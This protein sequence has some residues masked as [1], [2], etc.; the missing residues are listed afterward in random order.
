MKTYTILLRGVMP[1]GKNKVPMAGLRA[2]LVGAGVLDVR[3]YIQSGNVVARSDLG[4]AALE[5]LVHDVIADHFG[6]DIV[7]V[8]RIADRFRAILERNPFVGV[9]TSK[10]YFTILASKP[11]ARRLKDFLAADY[12]PDEVRVVGDV[13]YVL[14]DTRYSDSKVNN[15]FIE[16]K[17]GVSATT[18]NFNTMSKLVE[19]SRVV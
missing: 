8:A 6:G 4:Q 10:L 18:R 12:A 19:L 9:D 11:D 13:V 3:T 16:R 1:T 5:K 15:N 17:L 7:V 14:Y 2:A